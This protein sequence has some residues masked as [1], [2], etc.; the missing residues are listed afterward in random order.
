MSDTNRNRKGH[1]VPGTVHVDTRQTFAAMLVMGISP[2]LKYGTDQPDIS[3]TGERKFTVEVAVTYTTEPGM[4][5]VS[6]VI[7]V[8]LT[9]GDPSLPTSI[10]PGTPVELDSLRCGV[11]APEQRADGKGIRGGRL[12]WQCSGIRPANS[13]GLRPVKSEAS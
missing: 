2:K 3:P 12:Y 8:T 6:E 5:P 7:S 13:A 9:G 1:T 11:S 10:M 4:R